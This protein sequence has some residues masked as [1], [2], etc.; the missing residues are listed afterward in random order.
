MDDLDHALHRQS[1]LGHHQTALRISLGQLRLKRRTLHLVLGSTVTDS[2]LLV[3]FQN[4]GQ[5]GVILTQDQRVV[6]VFQHR[7]SGFWFELCVL[8]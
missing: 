7:P 6:K 3:H 2:L 1:L 8:G 4:C 5:K